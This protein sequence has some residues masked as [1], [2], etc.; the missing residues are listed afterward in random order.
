M[1]N[2]NLNN[3]SL[4]HAHNMRNNKKKKMTEKTEDMLLEIRRNKFNVKIKIKF[5]YRIVK[6]SLRI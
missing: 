4:D 6:L 5:Y 2:T 3:L 1:E